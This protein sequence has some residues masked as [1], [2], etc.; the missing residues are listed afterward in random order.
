MSYKILRL[1]CYFMWLVCSNKRD[2]DNLS[3]PF[4]TSFAIIL[5]LILGTFQNHLHDKKCYEIIRWLF[6]PLGI[7][8]C[9]VDF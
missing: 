6:K 2:M 4:T 8:G 3:L 5:E 1:Y 7:M 9:H